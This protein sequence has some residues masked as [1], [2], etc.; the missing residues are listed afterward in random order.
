MGFYDLSKKE[1][2]KL[3]EQLNQNIYS[4]IQKNVFVEQNGQKAAQ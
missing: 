4:D 2:I 3:V 1:R